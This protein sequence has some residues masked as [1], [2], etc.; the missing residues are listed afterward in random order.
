MFVGLIL[1]L[2][3]LRLTNKIQNCHL[4]HSAQ[5]MDRLWFLCG[6]IFTEN[7]FQKLVGSYPAVVM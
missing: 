3:C 1:L 5:G 7:W 6:Y 2:V 4:P